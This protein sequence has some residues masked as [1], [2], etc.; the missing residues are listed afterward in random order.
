MKTMMKGEVARR[1]GEGI[2]KTSGRILAS[3]RW[4]SVRV[5]VRYGGMNEGGLRWWEAGVVEW[6]MLGGMRRGVTSLVKVSAA[7]FMVINHTE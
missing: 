5:P 6:L 2:R 4:V 1:N 3:G 7:V